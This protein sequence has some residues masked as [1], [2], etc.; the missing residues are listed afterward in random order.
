[1]MLKNLTN[2]NENENLKIMLG[3]YLEKLLEFRPDE[4]SS[5]D[6]NEINFDEIEIDHEIFTRVKIDGECVDRV[7][8]WEMRCQI[9][10]VFIIDSFRTKDLMKFKRIFERKYEEDEEVVEDVKGLNIGE[11]NL[12]I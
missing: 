8:N 9:N 1:M 7:T 5:V 2:S 12:K 4:K 10:L 11:K 3:I 6:F